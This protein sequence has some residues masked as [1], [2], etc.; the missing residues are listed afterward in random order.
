MQTDLLEH[1]AVKAW[2]ELQP[3]RAEPERLEI[4][5]SNRGAWI[6]LQ[7]ERAEHES[8]ES[9]DMKAR[10]RII[11]GTERV[12]PEITEILKEKR[13][14]YRLTGV[15]PENSAVIAKQ[16]EQG[17][18]ML[19]HIIYKE[20]LSRL[21]IP[22]PRCYGFVEESN[23]EICWLFLED[24]GTEIFQ[25]HIR[26]HRALAARWLG[27]MHTSAVHVAAT[28]RLPE[29]GPDHYLEHLQLA[30]DAVQ[31]AIANSTL[32]SDDLIVLESIISQCNVLESCWSKVERFCDRMPQTLVH[33][34]FAARNIR[35]RNSQTG[36]ALLPFDWEKAGWGTPAAD[37]ADL[38]QADL[39]IYWSVVRRAWPY[40]DLQDIEQMANLGRIFWGLAAISWERWHFE[41]SWE[42]W[43]PQYSLL[44]DQTIERAVMSMKVY[45]GRIANAMR[46]AT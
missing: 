20:I 14:I 16:C 41:Y 33:S 17:D 22:T 35:I 46:V 32:S 7:A 12:Q 34:D 4:L 9:R 26:K 18:G 30:R 36:I 27:L 28:A 6:N 43:P 1:P 40:L 21:S 24:A 3:Y 11:F 38:E 31:R 23:G 2:I 25:F 8:I 13:F 42:N 19:E 39:A 5:D 29:R 44:K 37:L 45:E 10:A 15:G